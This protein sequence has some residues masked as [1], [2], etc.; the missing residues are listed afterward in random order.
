[1]RDFVKGGKNILHQRLISVFQQ[2]PESHSVF[3]EVPIGPTKS[4]TLWA[5]PLCTLAALLGLEVQ[6][7][8]F[9]PA[10]LASVQIALRE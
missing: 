9:A 5:R 4:L 8:V 3:G 1:M 7:Y 6:E 10:G 2:G